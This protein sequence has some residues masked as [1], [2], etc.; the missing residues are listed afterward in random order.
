MVIWKYQI[1]QIIKGKPFE[2]MGRKA[3]GLQQCYGSRAAVLSRVRLIFCTHFWKY[4]LG[5]MEISITR[6][7]VVSSGSE[8][9]TTLTISYSAAY[10]PVFLSICKDRRSGC[11]RTRHIISLWGA[12]L[13]SWC[14]RGQKL[15]ESLDSKHLQ[16]VASSF[17]AGA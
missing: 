16:A 8:Y 10:A 4:N 2:R 5:C 11:Q 1:F 7:R 13:F 9:V 12:K 6:F 3:T 14:S 17:D 15:L